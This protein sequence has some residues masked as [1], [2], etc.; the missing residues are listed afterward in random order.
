MKDLVILVA[1]SNMEQSLRGLLSRRESLRIRPIDSE[2][3]VHPRRD[4]GC[5]HE[6]PEFLR[7]LFR[8]Y[9]KAL[10]IFDHEGSGGET[11]SAAQWEE[12]LTARLHASGWDDRAEV[13]ILEPN[14]VQR[15]M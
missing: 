14:T 11:T 12:T 8:Q 1:D 10:V 3:F 4:P 5:L 9:S 7:S 15:S 6:A 13:L 2:I